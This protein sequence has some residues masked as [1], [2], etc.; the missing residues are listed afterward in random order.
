MAHPCSHN[1]GEDCGE[2]DPKPDP[3]DSTTTNGWEKLDLQKVYDLLG[4]LLSEDQDY[5][6]TFTLIKKR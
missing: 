4:K 3:L 6:V 5:K 1:F 2:N